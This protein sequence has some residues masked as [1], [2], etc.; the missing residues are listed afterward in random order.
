V[1][2]IR[3]IERELKVKLHKQGSFVFRTVQQ[4]LA[5]V[6]NSLAIPIAKA[7]FNVRVEDMNGRTRVLMDRS[8]GVME[9]ETPNAIHGE[10]D[11]VAVNGLFE[12]V[13]LNGLSLR[14]LS[15]RIE[16]VENIIL[17]QSNKSDE[18]RREVG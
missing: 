14:E 8:L 11:M 4:E 15:S 18:P 9:L 16:G 6:K 1:A 2:G 12:D 17:R 7:G 10:D 13:V 5:S 3:L